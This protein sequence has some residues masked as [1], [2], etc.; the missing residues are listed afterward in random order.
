MTNTP[1]WTQRENTLMTMFDDHVIQFSGGTKGPSR[2][3]SMF[4]STETD[5][6]PADNTSCWNELLPSSSM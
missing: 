5:F 2:F 1:V 6:L 4:S 3:K